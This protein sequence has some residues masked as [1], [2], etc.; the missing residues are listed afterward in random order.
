MENLKAQKK[1]IDLGKAIVKELELD[2]GVDTL[3]KWMAHYV[4]E[5]IELSKKLAG[6]KKSKVEKECFDI[7]LKL[8]ENRWSIPNKKPFFSDFE[9]LMETLEKLNP[10]REIPFFYSPIVQFGLGK[11][12][13]K[14]EITATHFDDTL[15]VDRLARSLIFDLLNQAVDELELSG[16]RGELIR[17]AI[18]H[19]DHLD[20]RIIRITSDY[21]K[22]KKSQ[23]DETGNEFKE[24]IENLQSRI[25]NL[26][27]FSV[28]RDSLMNRYKDQLSKLEK[29]SKINKQRKPPK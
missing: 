25:N 28:L 24:E 11:N 12:D 23:E 19:I 15:K 17:N 9:P 20:S 14:T 7:I 3:S 6:N 8:W 1:I 21:N 4:A 10:N 18:N 22:S 26:E 27:E 5:K 13:K 29:Q 16:E 2:P